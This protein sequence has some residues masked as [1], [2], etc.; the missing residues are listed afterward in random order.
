MAARAKSGTLAAT[1]AV[2]VPIVQHGGWAEIINRSAA[3]TIWVTVDGST[4]VAAADDMYPVLAGER[5]RLRVAN[6]DVNAASIRLVSSDD[7]VPY[8][9]VGSTV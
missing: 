2:T 7:A 6:L 5:V 9:V 3:A 4:P 8:T 1:V